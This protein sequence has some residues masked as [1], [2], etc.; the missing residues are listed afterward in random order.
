M[1]SFRISTPLS[2]S[3]FSRRYVVKKKGFGRDEPKSV[4]INTAFEDGN[5]S[6]YKKIKV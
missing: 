1:N 3:S 4:T 6:T 5:N 2:E